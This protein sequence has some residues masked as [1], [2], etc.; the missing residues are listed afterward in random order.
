MIILILLMK[1]LKAINESI[2]FGIEYKESLH[3]EEVG[4]DPDGN[5]KYQYRATISADNYFNTQYIVDSYLQSEFFK[6]LPGILTGIGIIGTFFGLI[7]GLL[8][9]T[10]FED[11]AGAQIAIT[12]L[13]HGVL[14][15]FFV[16][17][18]AI[19]AA[20]V[21][22]WY[23]K[24]KYSQLSSIIEDLAFAIDHMVQA[25]ANEEYLQ[26]LVIASETSATQN[27]QLK[28]ALVNDLKAILENVANRQIEATVICRKNI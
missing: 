6:H 9:F 7:I 23:E 4:Q 12:R 10:N 11:A 28:D 13:L 3:Y 2:I 18:S 1:Y 25:G 8:G 24:R 27:L 26:R 20:M 14:E 16:S 5:K 15:A 17:A 21:I 19:S 22:T